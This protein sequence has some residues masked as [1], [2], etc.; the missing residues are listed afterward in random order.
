MLCLTLAF[1]RVFGRFFVFLSLWECATCW[2]ISVLDKSKLLLCSE[3]D[4]VKHQQEQ[5]ECVTKLH[6]LGGEN[7]PEKLI[8]SSRY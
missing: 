8:Y 1:V 6:Q 5:S 4:E 7:L 3:E 2:D